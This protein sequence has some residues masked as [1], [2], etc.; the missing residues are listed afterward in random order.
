[1]MPRLENTPSGPGIPGAAG[2]YF[3]RLLSSAPQVATTRGTR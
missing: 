1:M 2:R 3:M